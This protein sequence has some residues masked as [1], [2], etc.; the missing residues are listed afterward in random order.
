MKLVLVVLA[1][2]AALVALAPAS[3][4]DPQREPKPRFKG[5]ELYSWKDEK[6]VWH[7]ALLDGTNEEK[8]VQNI[9]VGPTVY[10]GKEK[11]IAA[12]KVLAEGEQVSWFHNVTGFEF[13]PKEDI[14]KLDEAAKAAKIKL[15]H[16]DFDKE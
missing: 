5:V 6:G 7:F 16:P 3:A 15:T 11:L 10:T 8:D 12:L 4:A 9:K 1:C 13:P 2:A 14:K